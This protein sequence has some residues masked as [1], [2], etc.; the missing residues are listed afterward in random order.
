MSYFI[1]PSQK[2]KVYLLVILSNYEKYFINYIHIFYM[3]TVEEIYK[4]VGVQR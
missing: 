3:Y 4:I 1:I 2:R